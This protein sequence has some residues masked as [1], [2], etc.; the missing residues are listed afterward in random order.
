MSKKNSTFPNT[1]S[2]GHAQQRLRQRRAQDRLN[3]TDMANKNGDRQRRPADADEH[4]DIFIHD[5]YYPGAL[6]DSIFKNIDFN[7]LSAAATTERPKR[8]RCPKSLIESFDERV[9]YEEKQYQKC[10]MPKVGGG[11]DAGGA[12]GVWQGPATAPPGAQPI[13]HREE[14][15]RA[16]TIA[17]DLQAMQR[18]KPTNGLLR[19]IDCLH[20]AELMNDYDAAVQAAQEAA[21]HS[22]AD[23]IE[24]AAAQAAANECRWRSMEREQV[25]NVMQPSLSAAAAHNRSNAPPSSFVPLE[26]VSYLGRT[27]PN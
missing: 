23:R 9:Q 10:M 1:N 15:L 13:R 5:Q 20:K 22:P 7:K 6:E 8:R 11:G 16:H 19:A 21:R 25:K 24:D 12:G 18:R 3:C 4:E 2:A 26:I 14:S 27:S 17:I